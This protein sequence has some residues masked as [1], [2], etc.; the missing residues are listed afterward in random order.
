[1]AGVRRW[2]SKFHETADA[3]SGDTAYNDTSSTA[4]FVGRVTPRGDPVAQSMVYSLPRELRN[5]TV[6]GNVTAKM[7]TQ[8]DLESR[9]LAIVQFKPVQMLDRIGIW[10]QYLALLV[11]VVFTTSCDPSFG[12]SRWARVQMMPDP[13]LVE[14]V[15]RNAPGVQ[16][17]EYHTA[18]GGRPLTISGIKPPDQVYTFMYDG[19]PNV[20]GQLQFTIDYAGRVDFSQ[21]LVKMGRRPPQAW[22]DATRPVMIQIETLLEKQCGLT[23]L[24]TSVVERCFGVKC[25]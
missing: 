21:Y 18:E 16:K 11:L 17:V 25:K 7:H 14:T 9:T 24:Q 12:V 22:I 4:H 19:E 5:G 1:M 2:K 20:H 6:A 23:G 3:V 13:T 8:L 15:I 10:F